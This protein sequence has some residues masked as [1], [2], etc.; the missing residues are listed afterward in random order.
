MPIVKSKYKNYIVAVCILVMGYGIYVWIYCLGLDGGI[1]NVRK[2]GHLPIA[3]D[4]AS[5][6]IA[7]SASLL[8]QVCYHSRISL[9]L[10]RALAS[11]VFTW[12]LLMLIRDFTSLPV[13]YIT[14]G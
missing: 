3:I 9:L 12:C 5:C 10:S 14:F 8:L 2:T 7:I 1:F 11:G 4:A 6:F 13:N